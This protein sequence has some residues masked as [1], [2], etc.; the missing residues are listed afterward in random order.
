MDDDRK[1]AIEDVL[2]G[3]DAE[4]PEMHEDSLGY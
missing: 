3:R 2:A 4:P 1:K